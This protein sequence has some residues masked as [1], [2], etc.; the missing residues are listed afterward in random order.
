MI[1]G[2]SMSVYKLLFDPNFRLYPAPAGSSSKII[3]K[4]RYLN[5]ALNR[6]YNKIAILFLDGMYFCPY[7]CNPKTKYGA[8][9]L[10]IERLKSS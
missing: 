6:T 1:T 7:I 4:Y 5:Q 2:M 9:Y 10:N 3:S 8:R